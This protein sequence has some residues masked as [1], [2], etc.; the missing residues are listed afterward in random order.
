MKQEGSKHVE[1]V[2]KDDKWQITAGFAVSFTGEFLPTQLVY[3]G[4]TERCLS[5]FQ[6]PPD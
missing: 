6:F 1:V 4:K 3:Q 5:Q 2:A